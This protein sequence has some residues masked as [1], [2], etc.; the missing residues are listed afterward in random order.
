[1]DDNF[2]SGF[3]A[4]RDANNNDGGFG[5]NGFGWIWILLIFAVFAGGWGGFG[6]GG[7]GGGGAQGAAQNYVLNSDFAT[8]QRQLSDGFGSEERKLDSI[9]NGLCDGFYT[10]AQLAHNTD[11]AMANGF[12]QAE[13]SRANQQA[14]T[15]A[16]LNAMQMQAQ[17]CC[18]D[19]RAAIA[20]VKYAM[21]MGDNATQRVVENGFMQ[22]GYNMAD[23]GCQTRTLMQTNTRDVIDNQNA[24]T[25]AILDALNRQAIEAKDT[26]IAEQNQQIFQLQLA[27][28]QERQNNYLVSQLGYKCP[29]PAYV[30]QPPQQVTFP[31]NCCGGVNYAAAAGGCG[32]MG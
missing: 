27:A 26:K 5:N 8:L 12:A 1:M 9:S 4:G 13:L 29:Q 20:D 3:Y 17:Q 16:Q 7:F 30:V 10:S 23:Q 21:A 25:R 14:A 18:C 31:T 15:M 28:S 2:M 19:Q 32:C 22:T 11:M 24:N 6:F